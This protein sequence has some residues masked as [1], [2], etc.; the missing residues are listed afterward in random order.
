MNMHHVYLPISG[1]SIDLIFYELPVYLHVRRIIILY[2]KRESYNFLYHTCIYFLFFITVYIAVA[3]FNHYPIRKSH[4]IIRYNSD[5]EPHTKNKPS[6]WTVFKPLYVLTCVYCLITVLIISS[7]IIIY[8]Y[9]YV[10]LM[11]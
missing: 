7:C 8:C 6:V 10:L 11:K 3:V 4:I 5:Y 1:Q 9:I 2:I